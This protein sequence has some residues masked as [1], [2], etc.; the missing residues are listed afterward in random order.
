MAGREAVENSRGLGLDFAES[1]GDGDAAKWLVVG[2]GVGVGGH[3]GLLGFATGLEIATLSIAEFERLRDRPFLFIESVSLV[4]L[5]ARVFLVRGVLEKLPRGGVF[6]P[7]GT[8]SSTSLLE[9]FS[10]LIVSSLSMVGTS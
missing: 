10:A 6:S 9:R 4:K 1:R 8:R 2:V 5:K 7:M 3:K